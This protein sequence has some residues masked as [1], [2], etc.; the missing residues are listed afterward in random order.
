MA[1]LMVMLYLRT[2]PLF[3]INDTEVELLSCNYEIAREKKMKSREAAKERR[4]DAK[5]T[6]M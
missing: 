4:K 5:K 2:V 3:D 1:W 6:R